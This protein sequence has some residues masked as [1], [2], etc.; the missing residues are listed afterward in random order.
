MKKEIARQIINQLRLDYQK[1]TKEFSISRQKLWPEFDYLKQFAKSGQRILDLGCGNGRLYELFKSLSTEG[2]RALVY[3]GVDS[4]HGLIKEARAR[5]EKYP[6]NFLEA[7]MLKLPLP[8]CKFDVVF[9]IASL[10]HIPSDAYRRQALLEAKRVLKKDGLLIMF[11]WNLWQP[12][13]LKLVIKYTFLKLI[14]KCR[15]DFKDIYVPWRGSEVKR[16]Y[17]AFTKKELAGLLRQLKLN[18]RENRYVKR[19]KKASTGGIFTAV[20]I[21]TVARK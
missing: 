20:N 9:M 12:R 18:L 17:H 14:G 16:Y 5:W 3:Y 10:Q 13:Y 11:N 1:I 2:E 8:A 4:V 6:V 21:L 19:D 15:L 7:D